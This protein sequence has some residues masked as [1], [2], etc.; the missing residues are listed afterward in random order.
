MKDKGDHD[1]CSCV[2]DEAVAVNEVVDDEAVVDIMAISEVVDAMA[3][4][5][6]DDDEA[7]DDAMG[8]DGVVDDGEVEDEAVD[9]AMEVDEVVDYAKV[10]DEV[11]DDAMGVD[12]AVDD[13]EVVDEAVDDAMVVYDVVDDVM[14]AYDEVDDEEVVDETLQLD[15]NTV[16]ELHFHVLLLG[17]QS[18]EN[19]RKCQKNVPGH[20]KFPHGTNK[21]ISNLIVL[22]DNHHFS[23]QVYTAKYPSKNI[24]KEN[25][26]A[27]WP[28][29]ARVRLAIWRSWVL[30]LL[31]GLVGFVL[32]PPK[33]K[34]T[35]TGCLLPVGVF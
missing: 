6:G 19:K 12:G 35:A 22:R 18:T 34:S 33:F 1:T 11:V 14:V 10:V 21:P 25:G 31:L 8:V 17:I 15:V 2:V 13:G 23:I 9:D 16:V 3:F 29:G 7:V 27:A 30:F 26:M 32:S 24:S 20:C 4:D 28:R 5:E